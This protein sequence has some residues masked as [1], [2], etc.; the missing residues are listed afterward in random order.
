MRRLVIALMPFLCCACNPQ[1]GELQHRKR[2]YKSPVEFPQ[3]TEKASNG[4]LWTPSMTGNFLFADQRARQAGDIV[5]VV[6][7]EEADAKRGASTM[8]K[9]ASEMNTAITGFLGLLAE[10]KPDLLDKELLGFKA[11]TDFAG[12]G[13]TSRTEKLTATVPA[14]VVKVLPNGNLFV[15]GTRTIL[16]NREEHRF[17]ISGVVRPADITDDNVVMSS[18]IAEAEIEFNGRG[19]ISDK[20]G[21]GALIRAIDQYSPF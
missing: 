2:V 9:R 12:S 1:L 15:E 21:P 8:T 3:Q 19:V 18:R 11:G 6:V 13:Q 17:Y 20:Q 16:V 10:F 14:T 7:R 4:A 5:T